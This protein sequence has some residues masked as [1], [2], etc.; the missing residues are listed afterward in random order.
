[1]SEAMQARLRPRRDFSGRT[2][3]LAADFC[4]FAAKD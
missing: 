3:L 4:R 1:V 2:L